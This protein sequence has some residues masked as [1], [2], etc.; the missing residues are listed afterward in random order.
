MCP[1]AGRG[2]AV[3]LAL[4]EAGQAGHSA[5]VGPR[6]RGGGAREDMGRQRRWEELPK[7]RPAEKGRCSPG[8][9]ASV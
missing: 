4:R 9:E 6:V 7:T 5:P 3:R 8:R 2:P 1:G